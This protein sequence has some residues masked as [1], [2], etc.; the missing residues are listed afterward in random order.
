MVRGS[1]AYFKGVAAAL[2]LLLFASG[3]LLVPSLEVG[4]KREKSDGRSWGGAP[5]WPHFHLAI[6]NLV[7]TRRPVRQDKA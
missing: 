7:K 5:H 1:S 4:E 3:G 6:S 2:S